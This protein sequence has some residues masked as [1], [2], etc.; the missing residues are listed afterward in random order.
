MQLQ[1]DRNKEY[2]LVLEGG[3]ARGA[4]Q[5]GAWQA[6][7]EAG[8]SIGNIAGTSV[9]ALNG[10][11]VCMDDL[12]LAREI[13][14]NMQFSR[15]MD[16]DEELLERLEDLH[17]RDVP[18]LLRE[19]IRI[20]KERGFDI[21]PLQQMIAQNVDEQRIRESKHDLYVVTYDLSERKPLVVN[22][23]ETPQGSIGDML[24]ASAYLIGFQRRPLGGKLYMDGGAVSNVPADVLIERGCK[25]LIVI[26]IYGLGYDTERTL[27]VPEDVTIHHIYPRR[28]L[29]GILEFTGKRARRNLALGYMDAQR[30]LYGLSG[31][32]YYFDCHESEAECLM[33]LLGARELLPEE[34]ADYTQRELLEEAFPRL[35]KQ[36]RCKPDWTYRELYLTLLEWRASESKINPY[37]IYTAGELRARIVKCP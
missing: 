3:G 7:K 26:R 36:L 31:R 11:L 19:G 2:G 22:V 28:D 4:Y 18:Q 21:A 16:V 37:Q 34:L 30:F 27:E 33:L 15:V 24:M 1:L 10:A 25:D 8:I 9:G 23:K 14:E 6:L 35:A 13:W 12:E 17:F 29:G 5:I 20:L 32:N